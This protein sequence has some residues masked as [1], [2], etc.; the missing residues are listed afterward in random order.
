MTNTTIT[1]PH[2]T[3][4]IVR[5]GRSA[6]LTIDRDSNGSVSAEISPPGGRAGFWAGLNDADRQAVVRFLAP[7]LVDQLEAASAMC[8]ELRERNAKLTA[9]VD[10]YADQLRAD[11]SNESSDAVAVGLLRAADGLGD[12]MVDEVNV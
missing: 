2:L 5:D 3:A 10:R 4:L 11:A 9:A 6:T 7:E 12:L 8:D 1:E